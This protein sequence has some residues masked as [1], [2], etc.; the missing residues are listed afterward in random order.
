M[1]GFKPIYMLPVAGAALASAAFP[2]AASANFVTAQ[3]AGAQAAGEGAS[4]QKISQNGLDNAGDSS[5][6]AFTFS[7]DSNSVCSSPFDAENALY[8]A[9]GSGAG[10]NA[11]CVNGTSFATNP[12]TGRNFDFAAADDPPTATQI[13]NANNCTAA[14]SPPLELHTIPVAQAAIAM[15]VHLPTGCTIASADNGPTGNRFGMLNANLEGAFFNGSGAPTW[16]TLL[17]HSPSCSGAIT[18]AVRYDKSG[19]TFQTENYLA[20][21][22]PTDQSAWQTAFSSGDTQDHWPNN[23]SNILYGGTTSGNPNH[24][25]CTAGLSGSPAV[26]PTSA[27]ETASE[28]SDCNGA[29][30]VGQAVLDTPGS[31]GYVDMATAISKGFAY[32]S[33]GTSSTFWVPVQNNGLGTTGA[34]FRDPNV[35]ANGYISG[36][37]TGGAN[38]ASSSYTPPSG[39]DPTLS[40]W[41]TVIGSN[42]NQ[43]DY[44]ACTLTYELLFNDNSKAFGDNAGNDARSRS[45]KD[46]IEYILSNTV[47]NDGQNILRSLN[48]DAL[49]AN[50]LSAARTGANAITW[51][52]T[53]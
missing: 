39:A 23:A 1:P 50:V 21:L 5:G 52:G 2:A 3:C 15:I 34:T 24:A 13:N 27:A 11:V 51:S 44:P 10:Q 31:I 33:K 46:Y 37:P 16:S 6:W 25:I 47:A 49:P 30:M 28:N 41:D 32:P 53:T 22:N 17:P 12:N 14:V 29:G 20:Q 36:N 7:H 38:C 18:R 8:Q 26:P 19:T 48:Y 43:A 40:A 45:V 9:T 35:N 42:P 4:L